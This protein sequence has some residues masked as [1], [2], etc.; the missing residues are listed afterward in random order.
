MDMDM[1]MDMKKYRECGR[2]EGNRETESG[3]LKNKCV[4]FKSK[5][6]FAEKVVYEVLRRI[7]KAVN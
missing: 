5:I 2:R 1:D 6:Q 7:I 3:L 4:Y